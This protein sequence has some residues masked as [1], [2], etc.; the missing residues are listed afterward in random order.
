MLKK[1]TD[2]GAKKRIWS[3]KDDYTNEVLAASIHLNL[4]FIAKNTAKLY[5]NIFANPNTQW[6][7]V[8]LCFHLTQMKVSRMSIEAR[9]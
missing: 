1:T 4:N 7:N 6:H 2:G 5:T 9:I 3:N 8:P